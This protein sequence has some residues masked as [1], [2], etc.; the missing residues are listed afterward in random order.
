MSQNQPI[1]VSPSQ[2]ANL[3]GVS[4][5]TIRRAIKDGELRY[6]VVRNV[7]KINFDSLLKWSQSRVKVRNKFNNDGIGQYIEDT[8]K[9]G[10][11]KIKNKL[12]SPNPQFAEKLDK[13]DEDQ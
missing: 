13:N 10:K 6:V 7:Y 11:W 9:A 2:A 1:R 4:E 12:F 8:S 5:K 3:F